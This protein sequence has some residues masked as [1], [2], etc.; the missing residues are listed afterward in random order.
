ML[1]LDILNNYFGSSPYNKSA[2]IIF[3]ASA[4]DADIA[5]FKQNCLRIIQHFPHWSELTALEMTAPAMLLAKLGHHLLT[6][7]RGFLP[8]PI[9]HPL[10]D[11]DLVSFPFHNNQ[12][13]IDALQLAADLLMNL[14]NMQ[15][16]ELFGSVQK[17]WQ[18]CHQ[19]HPDYQSA[20]LMHGADELD[21]PVRAFLPQ[22]KIYQYGWGANSVLM[23]ES[24]I[25]TDGQIGGGISIDKAHSKQAMAAFGF[26]VAKD[27]LISS[28]HDLAAT[29]PKIGFP[30]VVKPLNCGGG[31]GVTADIRS[32]PQLRWAVENAQKYSNQPLL[33]E[34]HVAG[35]D[36]RLVVLGGKFFA[37]VRRIP[38]EVT[39]DGKSTIYQ[40]VQR[41]NQSRSYNI[42]LSN[43]I[44]PILI[45]DVLRQH[46]TAQ[47]PSLDSIVAPGNKIRLRSNS[48]LSTGGTSLDVTQQVH[49]TLIHLIE[50]FS[51]SL[52]LKNVGFDYLTEDLTVCPFQ[53]GGVFIE[54]NCCPGLDAL[55]A[56]GI[57]PVRLASSIWPQSPKR[58]P[59]HLW[60][61][62]QA[63]MRQYDEA[64]RH[65]GHAVASLTELHFAGIRQSFSGVEL[66]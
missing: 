37:C 20:I 16:K 2:S 38:S 11:E 31:K 15:D 13:A 19:H 24:I 42:K 41:L 59:V 30:C 35:E 27:A 34:Q 29:I 25:E 57:H 21:I 54:F 5:L 47:Q 26:P 58:I 10:A 17:F 61:D 55:L 49:P 36:H 23:R 44:R 64:L 52:G 22:R 8:E 33:L 40:L 50:Q 32:E 4:D 66:I 9:L 48:N 43:Y 3:T 51:A 56:A 39:G 12:L 62:T 1:T 46:M 18:R 28:E 14:Q 60:I 53:G 63:K 65:S 6:E 45:D 7:V